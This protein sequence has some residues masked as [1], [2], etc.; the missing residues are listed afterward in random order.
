MHARPDIIH[1]RQDTI[2]ERPSVIHERTNIIEEKQKAL[3]EE[4]TLRTSVICSTQEW[5]K[6][7][8]RLDLNNDD[9]PPFLFAKHF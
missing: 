2:H 8:N 9:N 4:Q 5:S 7:C 1:E 3:H 6:P